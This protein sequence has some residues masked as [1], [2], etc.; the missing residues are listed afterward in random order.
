MEQIAQNGLT[1]SAIFILLATSFFV[2]FN[3]SK[4]LHFARQISIAGPEARR[5]AVLHRSVQRPAWR[6][7]NASAA[8]QSR[9]PAATSASSCRSPFGRVKLRKPCAKCRTIFGRQS[10]HGGF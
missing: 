1:D 8:S 5:R 6:S 9:R 3:V 10:L 4:L 2:I 7:A